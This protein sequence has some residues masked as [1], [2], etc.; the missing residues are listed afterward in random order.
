MKNQ[1][2]FS[3]IEL[4]IV[5]AIIMIIAAIA[6]PN[7][8][9]AKAAANESAAVGAVR[10]INVAET[11]YQTTYSNIGY[12]VQLA[13]LGDGGVAPCVPGPNSACLIDNALE[14]GNKGGYTFVATGTDGG[15]G[16]NTYYFAAATPNGP[17]GNRSF[18][19]REDDAVR[20]DPTGGAIPDYATCAA[21]NQI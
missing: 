2:G 8:L 5:V 19:V 1:K 3:L 18:C 11:S 13:D 9:Q 7:L 16:V 10:T 20:V 17:A 14:T 6:I 15:A 21:L 4:M 12:A